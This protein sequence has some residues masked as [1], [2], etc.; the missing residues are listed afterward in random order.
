MKP[1][2]EVGLCSALIQRP[3]NLRYVLAP[4]HQIQFFRA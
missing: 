2:T 1:S 4:A 3:E